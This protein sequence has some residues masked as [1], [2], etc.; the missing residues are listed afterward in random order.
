MRLKYRNDIIKT[1]RQQTSA[2]LS[3]V[4]MGL[5]LISYIQMSIQASYAT[6]GSNQEIRTLRIKVHLDKSIVAQ[7]GT[8][9]M[10]FQVNDEKS[11]QP[12]GGA[13]TSATVNYADGKTVRQFS[14]PTDTSGRSS[15]SW[16]IESNAPLGSYGVFYSVFETGYVSQSNFNNAFSVVAHGMALNKSTNNYYSDSS[17]LSITAPS[18]HIERSKDIKQY[19]N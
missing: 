7:G 9:A 5:I 17:S 15:M 19:Y 12:I 11:H 6:T 2:A 18:L 1:T 13:I 3:F 4:I 10:R 8:Q 14:A 16:Q